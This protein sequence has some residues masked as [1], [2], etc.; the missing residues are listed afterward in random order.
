[1]NSFHPSHMY[2]LWLVGLG[3]L[4]LA[5]LLAGVAFAQESE[6]VVVTDD[7]VNAIAKQLYCPVCEN[8][9]L[10]VCPTQACA[11][12]RALIA[13]KLATGWSE[14]QIKDYFVAQYGDRVLATPPARG[15]NWL[16][17]VIPPAI[18]LGMAFIL[19][20]A[21]LAWKKP[22]QIAAS[23]ITVTTDD[24][25]ALQLEEELKRKEIFET[26]ARSRQEELSHKEILIAEDLRSKEELQDKENLKYTV[27]KRPV[28]LSIW[29][30]LILFGNL[31][32]GLGNII[33]LFSASSIS[34]VTWMLFAAGVLSLA[35][36][37]FAV[38]VWNWKKWGLYGFAIS[39]SASFI[40]NLY[41]ERILDGFL[42][43]VGLALMVFLT[44]PIWKQMD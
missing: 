25:Y 33:V 29:L 16:A 3:T 5:V 17:Y 22:A 36:A 20:S 40:L 31:F 19:I 8:I 43:L 27:R 44:R 4:V 41:N 37:G 11:Q 32:F 38:A 35:N 6:P 9:P 30:L 21:F 23:G 18:F 39:A 28:Y 13:E 42:G 1:M 24:K 7:Q 12:W 34:K 26:E 14:S 10:D 15:L 2:R